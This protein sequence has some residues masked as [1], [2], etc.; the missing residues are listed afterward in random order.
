MFMAAY[1]VINNAATMQ[2]SLSL[3]F[4]PGNPSSV[5][6]KPSSEIVIN[7]GIM[8]WEIHVPRVQTCPY[9]LHFPSSLNVDM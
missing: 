9:N 3:T 1:C 7:A 2:L 4:P 6:M 5:L 8:V